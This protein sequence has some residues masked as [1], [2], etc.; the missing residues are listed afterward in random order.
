[1]IS[2]HCHNDYG[3][4]VANSLAG[5]VAGADQAHVTINGIGERS[6]NTSLEEFVMGC[7]NLY[8][9]PHEHQLLSCSTRP[10]AWS[11]GSPACPSSRTRR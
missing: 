4:A 6:G 3:L 9:L 1:M 5:V 11:T 8:A 10:R 7:F 2:V